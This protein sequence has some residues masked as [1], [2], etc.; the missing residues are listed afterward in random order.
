MWSIQRPLLLD[1]N[2]AISISAYVLVTNA[3]CRIYAILSRAEVQTIAVPFAPR[4]W[5]SALCHNLSLGP[6]GCQFTFH[7][8]LTHGYDIRSYAAAE[9][10]SLCTCS[11]ELQHLDCLVSR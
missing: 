2:L 8:S 3:L 11:S 5:Y 4:L 1:L 9:G 6:L 10:R 7:C